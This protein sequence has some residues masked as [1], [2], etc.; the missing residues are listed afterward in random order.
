M[1]GTP[2]SFQGPNAAAKEE[3]KSLV[4]QA[5]STALPEMHFATEKALAVTL[6][7][8]PDGKMDGDVDNIVKLT[9][10]GMCKHV[11]VDDHQ[12]ER[13]VVQRFGPD[14]LTHFTQPSEALLECVL[15]EKPVLYVRISDDPTEDL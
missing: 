1:Y 15:G 12:I 4:K 14:R 10:D 2:P 7:Y 13:V 9:L 3:W 5:S 6:Y 8:F 11:Y